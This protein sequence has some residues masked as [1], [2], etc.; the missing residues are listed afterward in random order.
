[1]KTFTTL[2][3]V[4]LLSLAACTKQDDTAANVVSEPATGN[5]EA[6]GNDGAFASDNVILPQENATHNAAVPQDNATDA[7]DLANSTG[8]TE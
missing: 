7:V 5:A 3:A 4:A 8:N 1:M 6:F 2:A